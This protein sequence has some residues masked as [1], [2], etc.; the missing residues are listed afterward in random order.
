VA[1]AGSGLPWAR[2]RLIFN[3]ERTDDVARAKGGV[4]EFLGGREG[5]GL[6][7]DNKESPEDDSGQGNNKRKSQGQMVE[8]VETVWRR[9][10]KFNVSRRGLCLFG[11]DDRQGGSDAQKQQE[12]TAKPAK[13]S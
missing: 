9:R 7:G 6:Q 10:R 11:V 13:P 12:N 3:N 5:D 2:G 8:R 4:Y 1:V